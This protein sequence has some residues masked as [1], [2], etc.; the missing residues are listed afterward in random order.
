MAPCLKGRRPFGKVAEHW[1][2]PWPRP[3]TQMTI[4]VDLLKAMAAQVSAACF[5]SCALLAVFAPAVFVLARA[6]A[7][8]A[9]S[10][11]DVAAPSA[12]SVPDLPVMSPLS[13]VLAVAAAAVAGVP[14]PAGYVVVSALARAFC[15]DW[16]WMQVAGLDDRL[17]AGRWAGRVE[18]RDS[19]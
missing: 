19:R 13:H 6:S 14:L 10:A 5:D 1:A 18:L 2:R 16:D 4:R 15:L 11:A 3:A 9:E 12:V 17:V 8:V 7:P